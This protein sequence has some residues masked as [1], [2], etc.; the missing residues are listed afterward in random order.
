MRY[1]HPPIT[2]AVV[3]LCAALV[4]GQ[5]A[6]L[7]Q[8]VQDDQNSFDKTILP[9]QSLQRLKV[10]DGFRATLFAAE[11]DVFQP[12]AAD[13]DD[14]GRLWVA[15]CFSHP[16]WKP[17]GNDRILI[18]D[19]SNSDGEFDTR[20]VF[21]NKGNYLTGLLYGHGGVWICNTPNLMFLPDRDAD[22]VPDGPPEIHLDGWILETP[23]N[24]FNN[25]TWG[26]DGWM[27]GSIG[28]SE[29]SLIGRPGTPQNERV[30]IQQGIW[31]Y[32]PV[33]HQFEVVAQGTVNPW[34]L[35]FNDVGEGFFTNCVT[36]HLWHLVPGAFYQG[37]KYTSDD[38][39]AAVRIESIADHLHWGGGSWRS[40]R[41]RTGRH[42]VAGGGHAHT[43]AM[44][45]LG[46]NW[47]ARYHDTFFTGNIH[48]NRINNDIL[49]RRRSGY[50]GHHGPDF[51]LG[52]HA[53]FRCLWQM[54]GPQGGVFIGDW[55]DFGECHDSDGTHRS[56]GRI[57]KIVY[58][59]VE[60]TVPPALQE[61]TDQELVELQLHAND[62]HVRHARRLLHER[63]VARCDLSAAQSRL[64]QIFSNHTDVTR[65]L[66]AL[67]AL[68]VI[69]AVDKTFLLEQLGH[70]NEHVRAWAV[71]LLCDAEPPDA[72]L[73]AKLAEHAAREPSPFV[74]LYLAS[75]LQRIPMS[76]RWDL[77]TSLVTYGCD[78]D[79]QNIPKMIWYGLAPLT[80]DDP[81]RAM[82]L[83]STV[84]LPLIRQY[85]ARIAALEGDFSKLAATNAQLDILRG[86]RLG[87]RGVRNPPLPCGWTEFYQ[88]VST[89]EQAELRHEARFVALMLG[90]RGAE[91]QLRE[92]MMNSA[93]AVD[94]R[95]EALR[96]LV[97]VRTEGLVGFLLELLTENALRR[98][99]LRALAAY[100]DP[101][102]SQRVLQCYP[103][104][105]HEEKQDALNLLASRRTY[106]IHM[107]RAIESQVINP[108]D[109]SAY[110]ARQLADLGDKEFEKQLK[111]IWGDVRETSEDVQRRM[112]DY[113]RRLT[114]EVMQHADFR[115]GHRLYAKTCGKCH[116]LFGEG[117]R[118]GPELTGSNRKNIDYLLENIL[119][120]SAVVSRNYQVWKVVTVDGRIVTGMITDRDDK[121]LI[122]QTINQQLVLPVADIEDIE[123]STQ[124]MMPAGQLDKLPFES[125]RDLIAYLGTEQQ[126]PLDP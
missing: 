50:I 33:S 83:L 9:T 48:G 79:D 15:E 12:I 28:F 97:E 74:R 90:D 109:I 120:P 23:H 30:E 119:A 86:M 58:G 19:D 13:M 7:P 103:T 27:Y 108:D 14:R 88:R 92:I 16:V 93:A 8:D 67:W 71:R 60:N 112:V 104:L 2:L 22:D 31:R 126:V 20:T 3:F 47:P 6:S 39:R 10:P 114:P 21:W 32:H 52:N 41:G 123:R 11:P 125:V 29:P 89:S 61:L 96:A 80:S 113:S 124:S 63:A 17:T 40:S 55:H 1:I 73:A 82:Q 43:G 84:Q 107:L 78:R 66:R 111:E 26:P 101:L 115:R 46:N 116:R 98:V 76:Y 117:G 121:R 57:Y 25:L 72:K 106:A 36:A 44:I 35:D 100:D 110:T 51:L 118:I 53:W 91:H 64:R 24:A 37:S 18:F 34:G 102:I 75:A 59:N 4:S 69:D 122:L 87:L 95:L 68:Y 62:W 45:Y 49:K 77:A 54:Y 42:S 70:A 5:S 99:T 38:P 94:E 81:A 105:D 56:S 85:I 65:Q